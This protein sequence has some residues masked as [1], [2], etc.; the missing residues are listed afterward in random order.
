[1]D[2]D[3]LERLKTRL[4]KKEE[5]FFEK[6]KKRK[7]EG[8]EKDLLRGWEETSD[9][10]YIL[11]EGLQK[12]K[13]KISFMK[14]IFIV[15]IV[16]FIV[17]ASILAYFWFKG[18]NIVSGSNININ[19]KG[20]LRVN[21]GEAV[22]LDVFIE[23]KNTSPLEL[24]DLKIGFPQGSVSIDGKEL[25]RKTEPL[26]R[27]DAG[28]SIK[29]SF[30]AF[31]FGEE[32]EEKKIDFVLEYRLEGSNAIFV[33]DAQYSIKINRPPVGISLSVPQKISSNEEMNLE[34]ETVSN[35]ETVIK[36][37][38]LQIDYPSGFQF[39]KAV[40]EPSNKDNTW[41]IGDLDVS[42]KR[43][44]LITG[45]IEGQDLEEKA[46]RVRAGILNKNGDFIYYGGTAETVVIKKPDLDLVIFLNGKDIKDN[47]AFSG[48]SIRGEIV[49]KNNLS[50]G[51]RNVIVELKIKGEALNERSISVSNGFYRT[52]DKT[53]VW[54]I[55]SLS[56]LNLI[57]PGEKGAGK[58]SFEV[59]KPLPI[60]SIEDKNFII[61]L[62]GHISGR[63]ASESLGDVEIKND[64][65]KE[66]KIASFLQ[67]ANYVLHYTGPFKNTGPM[68]PEVGSETTYT[69]IWSL[70][71]TS[72]DFSSV[73]IS[74]FLPP[75][76]RFLNKISPENANLSFE[77]S[78]GKI[79]WDAG[80]ITA[81]A[82]II[83]P[84]REI[85]FQISLMP[86]L[87]QIDTAPFLV[88]ETVL[89]GYDNFV[90]NTVNETKPPL[91]TELK[92]DPKYDYKEGRVKQ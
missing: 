32:N 57:A 12:K 74:S 42:K 4:Y 27:I 13:K 37:L 6:R 53:L 30:S 84:A 23:N 56:E 54:N 62:E 28:A 24:A 77:E 50:A 67:L 2:R 18:T 25:G 90:D 63:S 41:E 58:F 61:T 70:G 65:S 52:S 16:L 33:K 66:I 78:T 75:Y 5:T 92:N 1:M 79:I 39:L 35:S 26:G 36:N 51:V 85:A 71:N 89:E 69:V 15:A 46:F 91:D 82:G 3:N 19:I 81:G 22:L 7:S 64:A 48:N 47:I 73:K 34:I 68:P 76:V 14:I 44:F 31:F 88:L 49:W 72:N 17:S 60:K 8:L 10:E 11:Q 43:N 45:L 55:S 40:P 29:K 86:S 83:Q 9:P 21:G 87:N 80:D 59:L 38:V 20:P